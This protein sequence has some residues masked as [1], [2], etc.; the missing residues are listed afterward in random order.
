MLSNML[1][2]L[3]AVAFFS[4]LCIAEVQAQTI[5]GV[6]LDAE[7]QE[8][9]AG[10]TIIQEGTSNGTSTRENG[11]FEL[12]FISKGEKII[13][14]RFIGF[15]TQTISIDQMTKELEIKLTPGNT[16]LS[17]SGLLVEAT[18]VD[19]STPFTFTNVS[20]DEL[21]SKNLGQDVPF[22][23]RS[24][25]SVVTT[26]DAGTGIG[27]TG[28][29]IRG[30]DPARINV[31]INGIP[32]NDA[33]SHGVFW[34]DLPDIVS[35]VENIQIQRGVG[36][37]T[38]GAAAFG[39]S[40]N[41]QTS[42]NK[43]I[44]FAEIN[45]GIGSFNTR[46]A[47]LLLGSGIM[48]NGWMFEGR[49]SKILSDGY[50][51]RASADLYS[52]YVSGSKRGERSLLKAEIFSGKEI[53]YQ[54]WY[55]VEQSVI[56][57]GNRT[58][59]EAG[60]ERE[61]S[62]YENEVDNYRQDYYQL[63]YSY[64]LA[65]NW[66]FNSSLHYTKG[67]GYY[68][69]YKASE[70][71]S[72]YGITYQSSEE[73]DLIRRRW[74]DNDF[75][76]FVFS[77][78]YERIDWELTVGGGLNQY[79]GA[80]FGE[81]IWARDAGNS[82]I[83]DRYYDNDGN[84]KDANLYGKF[85]YKISSHINTYVD[86][87]I[88][89][90]QYNFLGLGIV[91]EDFIDLKQKDELTFF[92]P[93][94]G[95]V[96]RLGRNRAFLSFAKASKEPT[97]EEYV[98]STK[99]SRPNHEILYNLETGYTREFD[100]GYVGLSVYGMFYKDQL[101]LTGQINDVGAYIRSNVDNS[102]RVGFEL[103]GALEINEQLQWALNS[104][105]SRNKIKKFS[106]FI[107]DYDKGGQIERRFENTD[108]AFSPKLIGTSVLSYKKSNIIAELTSKY[109]SRQY[110]DNTQN[111]KRSIDP[112]FINDL[113]LSYSF[114]SFQVINGITTT[115]LISNIFDE[116]YETNGYT[117]GYIFEGEQRVNYYYP[118]AGTNFLFQIKWD[119]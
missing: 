100:L 92:N 76:G 61:G 2:R 105:I 113:R 25:P 116:E 110:L 107:D 7:T 45:T 52:F 28:I 65:D 18:R 26:S 48:D 21:S 53:T 16:H 11:T 89:N 118:Q 43:T 95:L 84:K 96:Y 31:T 50:I 64:E 20:N 6:V 49:L 17:E 32:V 71:L 33:E 47:N 27:Y 60:T 112:Y 58:F 62:P 14:I 24:T 19:E 91:N 111:N 57:S 51:D 77:T 66:I 56:E 115:L 29:R 103:E 69:Q 72:N 55:G 59:N 108:I 99:Q 42:T 5:R 75:Y 93:K 87:Q 40:I 70:N 39:A 117:Y 8:P 106:E 22:L 80:H 109:V 82:E 37:S 35:S 54:A 34:V 36:T 3:L 79:D 86:V 81:V 90:I 97:R 102:Y 78:L 12:S 101:V 63:H 44:P 83:Y 74:L 104:T 88:R 119:F 1:S 10:A 41:L 23:L 46:K 85:N 67:E 13:I 98:N 15:E 73:S 68:E 94:V 114:N 38:N 4:S 9:L 30:I